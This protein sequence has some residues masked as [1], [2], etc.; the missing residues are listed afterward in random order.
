MV[1]VVNIPMAIT[2]LMDQLDPQLV[3]APPLDLLDLVMALPLDLL[4]MVLQLD[5]LAAFPVMALL[6]PSVVV[7]FLWNM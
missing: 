3:M 4:V 2:S 5:L 6:N 7:T 1:M